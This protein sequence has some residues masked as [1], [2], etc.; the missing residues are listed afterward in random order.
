MENSNIKHLEKPRYKQSVE[1]FSVKTLSLWDP[2]IRNRS[3]ILLESIIC[4]YE[5]RVPEHLSSQ[6]MNYFMSN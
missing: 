2:K 6:V 5:A 1:K 4:S 3:L